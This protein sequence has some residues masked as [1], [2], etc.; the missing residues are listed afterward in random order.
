MKSSELKETSN[1]VD[2]QEKELVKKIGQR[3][4][5]EA[6]DLKR[7]FESISDELNLDIKRFER[8]LS[9]S[10]SY[11][12]AVELAQVLT[13][14]YPVKLSDLLLD[15]PDHYQ[16]MKIMRHSDSVASK[17][18]FNRLDKNNER[19]PYYE[20]RDT[21]T[22]KISPFKPEWIKELRIV[23]DS[24]PKNQDVA[25]N[26]GH[27]LHQMTAFIGPVNFYWEIKGKKYC[28]EMNTGSSNYITPFIRHSF[29]A[30]DK[31]TPA[32]IIAVTFSSDAGRAKSE[33]Y[34]IGNERVQSY[35]LDNRSPK[36]GLTQLIKQFL[37]DRCL[38][39]K[40]LSSISDKQGIKLDIKSLLDPDAN[41]HKEDLDKL[42]K[43]LNISPNVFELPKHNED[44]D[45]EVKDHDDLESFIF[46]SDEANP[47]YIINPLAGNNRMPLMSSF[48]F[49]IVS[50]TS[51][52]SSYLNTSLHSYIFN[53]G[54]AD[55]NFEW[56]FDGK[57]YKEVIHPEDSIYLE[58]QINHK[59]WNESDKNSSLFIFRVGGEIN[60]SVQKE[61]SSFA[62]SERVV[63]NIA[64]FN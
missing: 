48:N 52:K 50:K 36:I 42:A 45:V 33:F 64:W 26:N 27:F 63:E 56:I 38:S 10:A 3:F 44:D 5:S 35:I 11:N 6:N 4:L 14:N 8:I 15:L 30:R 21:A 16:G 9:G 54:E 40:N 61:I 22:A 7:T 17:R 18:I 25:Y 62:N 19:T 39:T 23:D 29:T 59:F 49:N 37:E 47:D 1:F 13:L 51:D 46:N 53:Y 41:K 12:E 57:K 60:L 58:P 34:N 24:N 43:L 28:K 32:I 20:Y 55:I 2:L 31:T